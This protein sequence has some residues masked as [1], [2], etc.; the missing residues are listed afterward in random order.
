MEQVLQS[1][2]KASTYERLMTGGVL[3]AGG[4]VIFAVA[5]FN[6]VTAGFF[7]VCPLFAATGIYCPG[8]GM[9]R[10]FHAL[11]Q[12]DILSALHFNAMLPFYAFIFGYVFI[13]TLMIVLRGRGLNYKIFRPWMMYSFLTFALLFAVMRNI[14]VYPLNLLAP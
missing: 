8:C 1:K 5:Y 13:S 4:A 10:A 2:L 6:P 7:P 14:P 9:T 11:F 3:L 12:G